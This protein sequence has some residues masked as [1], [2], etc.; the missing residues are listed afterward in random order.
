MWDA[1]GPKQ[2]EFYSINEKGKDAYKNNPAGY[3]RVPLEKYPS[4][5]AF[6]DYNA[7][8]FW[9]D[10]GWQSADIFLRHMKESRR[11]FVWWNVHSNPEI[12]LVTTAQAQAMTGGGLIALL[13]GCSVGGFK[14]PGSRSSVDTNTS[15]EK[16][17]LVS[18]V[19]GHSAFVAVMGNTHNR[20]NDEGA[21]PLFAH[22]YSGGYLGMA[23]LLRLRQQAKNAGNVDVL[24]QWHEM[25]IGDPFVDVN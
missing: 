15:V 12:S 21:T 3:K 17:V 24:R 10:E 9:M 20:V 23:H 6:L 13:S 18:V 14:Q 8:Q 11:R 19:Y 5:Q 25:L 4:L 1:V 16:N 2:I 22:M 7:K